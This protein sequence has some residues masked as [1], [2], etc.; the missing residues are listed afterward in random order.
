[1]HSNDWYHAIELPI[2]FLAEHPLG[3]VL[4][5]ARYGDYL[6]VYQG[7][8]IGGNRRKEKLFYPVLKNNIVLYANATV[9]GD[10]YIGNNVIISADSYIMNEVI[11]DNCIVFGRSPDITIKHRPEEEMK[12]MTSC[13]W[14]W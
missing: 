4:G 11:P 1:M 12:R 7:T 6:V 13:F 3:S 9:L 14:K 2:H 10:T 5:R 8:T